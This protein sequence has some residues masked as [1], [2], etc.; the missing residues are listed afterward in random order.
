MEGRLEI[1]GLD[2]FAELVQSMTLSDA[3][4][5]KAVRKAITCL[6]YTSH[7]ADEEDS[8]DHVG[9]RHIKK[10]QKSRMPSYD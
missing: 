3:D 4:E 7:A 9:R 5:K 6:L 1:E 8:V 10:K 2:E